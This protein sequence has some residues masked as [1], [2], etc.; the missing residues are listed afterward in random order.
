MSRNVFMYII[1]ILGFCAAPVGAEQ[2]L[3][4]PRAVQ[5]SCAIVIGRP[6]YLGASSF[7]DRKEGYEFDLD[8]I[9]AIDIVFP[10]IMRT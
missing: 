6:V 8:R 5:D 9:W 1:I 3:N 10:L 2:I 7:Y 4:L